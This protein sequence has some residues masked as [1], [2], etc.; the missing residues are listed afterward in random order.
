M[1]VATT[2]EQTEVR[3]QNRFVRFRFWVLGVEEDRSTGTDICRTNTR[4]R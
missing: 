3:N 4:P 1:V 2:L